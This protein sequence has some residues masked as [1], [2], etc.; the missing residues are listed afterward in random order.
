MSE[1]SIDRNKGLFSFDGM[2]GI[3][4]RDFCKTATETDSFGIIFLG[5]TKS[6]GRGT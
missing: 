5:R 6:F 1:S 2:L 3:L 4:S